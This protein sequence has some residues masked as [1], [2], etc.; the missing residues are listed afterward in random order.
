MKLVV[1]TQRVDPD[2]P[3]LGATVSM[4]RS[5]AAR[6]DEL[7]VLTLAVRE[8]S[9]PENVRIKVISGNSEAGTV[10]AHCTNDAKEALLEAKPTA[11]G[12]RSKF[13]SF[14]CKVLKSWAAVTALG[15]TS[16]LA[17]SY[18]VGAGATS[19][20]PNEWSSTPGT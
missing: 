10:L 17:R 11:S 4:L 19:K 2:D 9:L 8:A 12:G 1:I 3:A 7:V 20:S 16:D 15:V 14:A 5:L 6:V 18:I 13:A